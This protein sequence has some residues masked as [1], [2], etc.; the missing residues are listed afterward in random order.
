MQIELS[1]EDAAFVREFAARHGG[2][3]SFER[4]VSYALLLLRETERQQRELVEGLTQ[5]EQTELREAIAE[6]LA[7]EAAGRTI[8]VASAFFAQL[9]AK[10]SER[11]SSERR[12]G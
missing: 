8:E 10:L 9:R 6:G 3:A 7:D 5:E 4:V 12:A 11:D 2:E 1:A